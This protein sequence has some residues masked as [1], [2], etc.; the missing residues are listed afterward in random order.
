MAQRTRQ[1]AQDG[2][3]HD[4]RGELAAGQHVAADRDL[5]AGEVLDDALVEP[6]VAPAQ[7]RQRRLARELVDERVVEQPPPGVS[8]ITRRCSRRPTGSIP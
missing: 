4:H 7:Q 2:V 5:V 1:L 6:L 8:A 3:A